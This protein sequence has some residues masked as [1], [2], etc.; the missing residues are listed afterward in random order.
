MPAQAIATKA[1]GSFTSWAA[2]SEPPF[3]PGPRSAQVSA[4]FAADRVASIWSSAIR[5][6]ENEKPRAGD[7][8]RGPTG[9]RFEGDKHA[10][11]QNLSAALVVP[12]YRPNSC[13]TAASKARILMPLQFVSKGRLR[14]LLSVSCT[15]NVRPVSD[16]PI[17]GPG[18]TDLDALVTA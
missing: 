9:A 4:I 11:D 5:F 18:P 14:P 7:L 12:P 8:T 15:P 1:N 10:S 3:R 17:I 16:L 6:R 13:V 2:P